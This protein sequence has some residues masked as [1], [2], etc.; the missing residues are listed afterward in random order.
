MRRGRPR[1]RVWSSLNAISFYRAVGF[2]PE[3]R[4]RWPVRTGIELDYVLMGKR[5]EEA[6]ALG[7]RAPG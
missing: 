7:Q 1:V 3:R 4:A 2:A 6:P 5:V